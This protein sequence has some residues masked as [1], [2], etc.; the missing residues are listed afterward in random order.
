MSSTASNPDKEIDARSTSA[1]ASTRRNLRYLYDPKTAPNAVS[2]RRT[3][4]LLRVLRSSIIF[5]FWR[6]VRY[7]KYVAIGS[8]VATVGAGAFG[9]FVSG[10]GFVLAPTGIAGTIFAATVWGIGRYAIGKVKKRWGMG[11]GY[12]D[13][14]EE[15]LREMRRKRT[16]ARM[17]YGADAMPW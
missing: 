15:E 13:E 1:L 9:T 7:A 6:I 5:V 12:E 14:E 4:A 16:A 17:E 10:A 2:S 11:S 3:R 8:L